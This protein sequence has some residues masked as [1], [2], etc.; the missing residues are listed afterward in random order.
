MSKF[1][2]DLIAVA[3]R[4]WTRWGGP[5]EALDSTRSGYAGKDM[6][7]M[8]PYWQY[9][10]D[11]WKALGSSLD[12]KDPVAWSAA[13]ISYCFKEGGAGAAFPYHENH[14]VYVAKI[15]GGFNAGLVLEDPATAILAPGDLL[16]ASR[17]GADCRTPPNSFAAAKVELASIRQHGPSFCSHCDIVVEIRPGSADV[18]GG[19]VHDAVTRTTYHLDH[20]GHI[21][22]G[23]RTFVGVVKTGL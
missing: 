3:R 20:Q 15:D 5:S 23:R 2:D 1:T 8:D 12:G 6:E 17:S 21:H 11:Y 13:F 4:E 22:D 19:N 14:S 16:W 9:V 18:I 10:G 7:D